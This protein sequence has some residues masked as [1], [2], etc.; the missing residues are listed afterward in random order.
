MGSM[1]ETTYRNRR[2]YQIENDDVRATVLREGGHIAEILH[3]GT[4]VNPLWSPPWPSIEP[5]TYDRAKHPE[6]GGDAESKLLSGIMGHNLC[7]DL[8][9]SPSQEEA[10]AG[11]T[12]HGEASVATYE[13]EASGQ[14]LTQRCELP[15]AGL[16]FDRKIKLHGARL[17]ISERVTNNSALDRP[18]AWTQHVTL[19]PPFIERGVTELRAP[20]TKSYSLDTGTEF[21]WPMAPSKGGGQQDLRVYTSAPVSGGFTTHLMDPHRERAFF[22]AFSPKSKVLL[23]YVWK[24]SDFPWLGIWEENHSRKQP[25]WNG[26]TVTRGLEFGA[27]PIPE[28]RRKMIDRNNLFGVPAYRWAPGKTPIEVRYYAFVTTADAMPE[29]PEQIGM[30]VSPG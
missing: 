4:G 28:S 23:G 5:S 22:M 8:F 17:E 11:M 16:R 2:A 13:I 26:E 7:L 14:E 21:F 20:G 10:A 19:G 24:R 27:S 3:K 15:Q 1:G 30:P 18:I 12:V 6:Y 29:S 25:P 9:G